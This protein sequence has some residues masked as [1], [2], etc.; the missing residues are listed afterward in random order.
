MTETEASTARAK[1]G[2]RFGF[3]MAMVGAMV[4]SGNIWRMPY[5]TGQNGG[6]AFLVA[7][8][9]LLFLIAIPGLMAE[10]MIGRHTQKGVI[11]TFKQMFGSSRLKDSGWWSLS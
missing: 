11:G 5:T 8:I 9:V 10:T 4:G 3:L 1:W 6:G 2:S 7:Y